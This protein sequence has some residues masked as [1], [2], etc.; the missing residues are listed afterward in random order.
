[1]GGIIFSVD[2]KLN[3]SAF[4]LCQA[5]ICKLIDE[6][7]ESWQKKS[8]LNE[9]FHMS[10]TE[11]G[12]NVITGM[13][14]MD[15]FKPVGENGEYPSAHR[16]EGYKKLLAAHEWKNSFSISKTAI[17]ED[18]VLQLKQRP[19]SFINGYHR[20]REN[21]GAALFG[22]AIQGK[23][24]V[25]FEGQ[26]FDLTCADGQPIFS[27][28]HKPKIKG[29][30]QTNLF[31][32]EFSVDA[33]D[34]AEAN[35]QQFKGDNGELMGVAPVTIAIANKPA[36]KRKVFAVVGADLD[37]EKAGN[38]FNF[39]YGRWNIKIWNY[40]NQFA[41]ADNEPWMLIDDDYNEEYEG[42][43]WLDRIALTVHSYINNA[44]DANV[45]NG[46]ARFTAGFNDFRFACLGG[47]AG[48]TDLTTLKL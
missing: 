19:T 3:D 6:K 30:V 26:E 44:N 16:Q 41:G 23:K 28:Q 12:V 17:E 43:V 22:G 7:A 20:T 42:A 34:R 38:G 11:K 8:M 36:L 13:T 25:K 14:A 15:G 10:N 35:M 48:G 45:W 46:R 37:P 33:L 2:S 40:L 24:S 32:N 5:P 31:S 18:D 29:G 39:Q 1:M 9:F 27:T 21:F 47:V 4:G